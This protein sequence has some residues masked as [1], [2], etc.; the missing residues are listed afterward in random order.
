MLSDLDAGRAER[1]VVL[2]R[3]AVTGKDIL[4]RLRAVARI[5]ATIT[6]TTTVNDIR[7]MLAE[8][9]YT[10]DPR[11]LGAVFRGP[12]WEPAGFDQT[13]NPK[14]HARPIRVFKLRE[15]HGR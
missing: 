6:G 8:L 15:Q 2:N 12:E 3:M 13:D 1:E 10:G 5:V 14:A 7:P 9:G 4:P 11:I